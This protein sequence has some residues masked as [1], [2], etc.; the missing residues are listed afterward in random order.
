MNNKP[1]HVSDWQAPKGA[2][3]FQLSGRVSETSAGDLL[4]KIL[5]W[6]DNR[7]EEG[8]GTFVLYL[9]STG[10]NVGD[11]LAIRGSLNLARRM[12]HKIVIV[13]LGRASSCAVAIATAGDEVYMDSNAWIMIHAVESAAEGIGE[14]L[15]A[16]GAYVKRLNA[17]T[18]ALMAT[19]YW[20]AEEI[21]AEVKDK[22]VI[23]L[24]TEQA[25]ERGLINGALSEPQI[26]IRVPRSKE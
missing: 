4:A 26:N 13:I 15:D 7:K 20:S 22:T 10:G 21:R 16:E 25:W 6:N 24:S 12:G 14:K 17:Q 3:W 9:N 23:W 8:T 11:A 1:L 19:P 5:N 2:G 18:F